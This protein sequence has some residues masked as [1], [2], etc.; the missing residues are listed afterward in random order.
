[1]VEHFETDDI[2]LY[3]VNWYVQEHAV[4]SSEYDEAEAVFDAWLDRYGQRLV[5]AVAEQIA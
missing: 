3:F 1:M 4:G 5:D 2:R